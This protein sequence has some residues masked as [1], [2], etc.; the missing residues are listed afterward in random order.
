MIFDILNA[1]VKKKV[2]ARCGGK[3]FLIDVGISR[4][5]LGGM[6]GWECHGGNIAVHYSATNVD[7]HST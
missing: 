6:A 1:Q 7:K 5:Y 2:R 3:L 4:S